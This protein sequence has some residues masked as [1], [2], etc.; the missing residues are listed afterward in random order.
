MSKVSD[1]NFEFQK[2]IAVLGF[3]LL[4]VKFF[5][6]YLTG[7]VSILTDAMESIVNVVAACIGLFALYLSAQPPDRN[8]PFGHGK[9]EIIS[10][11][12][13]GTM[14][15]VAG[16][17][18]IVESVNSLLHPGSISDLDMGLVLIAGA[19]V[20]NYVVGR[21][22]IRRGRKNRSPALEA[23]GKHL[24]SDTYS[25]IGIIIGLMVVFVMQHMGYDGAWLD[26]SIAI[27]FGAIILFTGAKVLKGCVDDAMDKADFD[28]IESI[29]DAINEYRHDDWIDVYNL[30][31]IKYGPKIYV[32]VHVVF[33]RLMTVEALYFEK[34]ELDEAIMAKYGDSV[35]V[36]MT[37]V[38]C[39]EFNCRNCERNCQYR[40]TAFERRLVWNSEMICCQRV[41]AL[42]CRVTIH[43]K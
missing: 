37:P 12:L 8:H 25:S 5:A 22:A 23:S 33:P 15:M 24:C 28:L 43:E 2:I 17:M 9:I 4:A 16:G 10:A 3:A 19:A 41:H 34:I 21:I 14:I 29:T 20:A 31:L 27:V 7:S 6:Y 18:I 42:D 40:A 30:R 1:E 35:E 11:T 38:P 36:S 26:S 39:R 32:D 13:E